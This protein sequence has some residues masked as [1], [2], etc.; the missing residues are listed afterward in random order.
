MT[1]GQINLF[2]LHA[3]DGGLSHLPLA[4][5]KPSFPGWKISKTKSQIF[6]TLN[7]SPVILSTLIINN[8]FTVSVGYTLLFPISSILITRFMFA[9]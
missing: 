9:P 2:S 8:R 5:A 3:T 6:S 1:C 7:S 4:Q